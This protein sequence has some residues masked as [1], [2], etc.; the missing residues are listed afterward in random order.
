M[1]KLSGFVIS[2]LEIPQNIAFFFLS[3]SSLSF[4]KLSEGC[5][6]KVYWMLS[7]IR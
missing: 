2:L 5:L 4:S 6:N 1:S 7:N 3:L